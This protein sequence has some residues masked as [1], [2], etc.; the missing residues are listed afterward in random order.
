MKQINKCTR[1]GSEQQYGPRLAGE[2]LHDYLE[3][4][5]EPLACAYRERSTETDGPAWHP[6]TEQGCD[7]KTILRSDRKM[8]TGKEY[9][10]V[11]RRDFFGAYRRHAIV[12]LLLLS[13]LVTPTGDPFTLMV[14][15][16]PIYL[17]Y[18]FTA[19]L[20]PKQ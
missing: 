10:G 7:L 1:V 19:L 6:N 15:F 5:N 3:N 2:I 17:L 16:L 9:V 18:E 20:V 13:A 4:S 12:A 14:V 11:L 8:K